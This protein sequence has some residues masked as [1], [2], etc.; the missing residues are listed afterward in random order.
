MDFCKI[1]DRAITPTRAHAD[2]AGLDVY[3]LEDVVL[4]PGEIKTVS[5]GIRIALPPGKSGL[6]WPKS[7]LA[8]KGLVILGG[9]IDNGYQ[10]E[11]KVI[12]QNSN[13][14]DM[15]WNIRDH[16]EEMSKTMNREHPAGGWERSVTNEYVDTS[17]VVADVW[18]ER[19]L[20][21]P[22]GKP[23]TQL[24]IADL[25][26]DDANEVDRETFERRTTERGEGGFGS[27]SR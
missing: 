14:G 24:L 6:L 25:A 12:V 27:T 4:R 23:L 2:D 8:Q 1:D 21:I 3:A 9:C 16:I 26:F 20:T 7:G 5:T 22:Y 18:R 13:I 15:L 19:T 10:G 17:D 11:L